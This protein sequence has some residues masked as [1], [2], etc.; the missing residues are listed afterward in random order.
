MEDKRIDLLKNETIP[1]CVMKMALP[2]IIGLLV[3]AIYNIVDTMFVAWLG[4]QA[5]GATQIVFPIVMAL[6][7][8]GLTFGIGGGSFV[9]RLLGEG[10]KKRAEQV[11]ST[12]FYIALGIGILTTIFGLLFI[13]PILKMF[14][15][16][17]TMLPMA[18]EYGTFIMVGAT[19]QI[20]NMTLNNLL[21]SEGSAKNSMIAMVAGAC[22]NIALDPL[23]IFG[24][25][26]GVKGAAI[27]TS[28]SQFATMI[29]LI[30]Q[31]VRKKSL[32]HINIKNISLDS[33]LISEVF[34]MGSPSFARQ[35]LTSVSM[36][37][38]NQAAGLTG[39]DSAIAAIGI[40]SRTMMIIMYVIFGLS[41]GFQP[42]AGYN[43]GSKNYSRL[44]ESLHFTIKLSMS[45]ALV[46]SA[47]F[48]I[49]DKEILSMYRPTPE[50]MALA[51]DFVKYFAVSMV[52]MSFTNVIGVYYQAVGQGL[53]ALILSSARQGIFLIPCILVLP[54]MIGLQGVF[55]AQPI[56]DIL[57]LAL[58]IIIFIPTRKGIDKLVSQVA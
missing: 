44:K 55:I 21:R 14:G 9:S 18:K 27:A 10:D 53:P 50:V 37:L 19:A 51:V 1:K 2:S 34:K 7:A 43:Y 8:V 42:V 23:F 11:T 41:Q 16:T 24:F 15:A 13:E 57:T 32:L 36:A 46:S 38:L 31:Y 30:M 48:L 33:N 49:F 40:V 45:I 56:A 52:L 35:I 17:E 29:M 6:G 39:G 28:I 12:S 20:V 25:G 22:L 58:T 5:T 47:L 26:W 54:K 4:T 3:M